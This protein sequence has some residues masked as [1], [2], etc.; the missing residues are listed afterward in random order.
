MTT[1]TELQQ[2]HAPC[3]HE[4]EQTEPFDCIVVPENGDP[5]YFEPDCP[6]YDEATWNT[7]VLGVV[8]AAEET[9][10]RIQAWWDSDGADEHN[11]D[12]DKM[13]DAYDTLAAALN[14]KEK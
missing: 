7:W 8:E 13:L 4:R 2:R 12:G 11:D 9:A 5:D 3:G 1:I 10:T 6:G 14:G